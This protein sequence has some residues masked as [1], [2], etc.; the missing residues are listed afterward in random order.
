MELSDYIEA[1]R[2][3]AIYPKDREYLT[4]GLISE[5]G[6]VCG[7]LKNIRDG[8]TYSDGQILDEISDCL[9]Y[10]VRLMDELEDHPIDWPTPYTTSST[11]AYAFLILENMVDMEFDNVLGY[12]AGWAMTY[13]ESIK[14]LARRNIDKLFS[15]WARGESAVQ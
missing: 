2:Q 4:L 15:R 13:G 10:A 5:V 1:T 9:W 12:I 14:E 7:K 6:E 8:Q 3:T 11:G